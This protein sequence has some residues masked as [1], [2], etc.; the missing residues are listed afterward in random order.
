MCRRTTC[1]ACQK[2]TWAG[3]GAHVDQVM[4]G[5]ARDERCRCTEEERAAA[6]RPSLLGRLLGR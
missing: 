5:V 2:V 3:C 4:A 6:R 1:R